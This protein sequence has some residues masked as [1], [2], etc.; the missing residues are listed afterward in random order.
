MGG[1]WQQDKRHAY[2][3]WIRAAQLNPYVPGVFGGLGEWYQQHGNDP[4]RAKRCLAKAVDLDCTGAE[5]GQLLADLYLADGSDDLCEAHLL[6]VTEA[7]YAQPW[8]WK[9]LGFLFL[10]QGHCEKA[11][12]ALQN[13]LSADRTD[14]ACWEGLC[15]AY[16]GIGRTHTAVKVA[17][18]VVELDPGRVSGHWQSAQACMRAN[19]AVA[20]LQHFE[21]AA[22][23]LAA[24]EDRVAQRAL[25]AQP[26]AI[27]K[28]ECLVA[29]AER[30]HAEGLLGR[31]ADASNA[32]LEAVLAL[33][34]GPSAAHEEEPPAFLLW[35]IVYA[36][37][38]WLSR[39]G[40]LFGQDPSLARS[41]TVR[42][43]V[44]HAEARAEPPKFLAETAG[45][46]ATEHRTCGLHGGYIQ[47]LFELAAR[48]ACLR[49]PAAS[50]AE[51]ASAAWADLGSVYFEHSTRF[52]T[53][54]LRTV[55]DD[56][57]AAES[58]PLLAAAAN[59]ALAAVQ[60]D[61]ASA[62]AHNLQGL[63]AM[64]QQQQAALAQHAF[65]M[66]SRRAPLSAMPWANLGFLYF[67]HGDVELAN[68]AF[69]RAQMLDPAAIL[70]WLGQAL[71]AESIGSDECVDLFEACMLL[72]GAS[73]DVADFGYASQVWRLAVGAG[74]AGSAGVGEGRE[75]LSHSSHSRLALAIY[76]ARRYVARAEDGQGAGHHLLGLLLEQNGEYECA[77]EA[78]QVAHE[79][80]ASSAEAG[81]LREWGALTC[82][83]R[84]QC[85]AA[86]Y[87]AA[88]ESYGRG[89]ALLQSGDVEGQLVAEQGGAAQLFYYVLGYGL[90]LFFDGQLEESLARF[91]QV[92][93][94]ADGA[95]EQRPHVAVMLAQVLWALGSEEHRALARQHLVEA[96]GEHAGFLPGLATLFAIGLLQDDGELV[97]AVRSELMQVHG[98][99][100]H[101]VPRLES[102][103][104]VLRDDPAGGRR[105]VAR[106]LHRE[107][108]DASLWLLLAD[109]DA[110]CQRHSSAAG[111]AAA[112]LQLFQQAMRGRQ[113]W[114][115]IPPRALLNSASLHVATSAL[116]VESRALA[117]STAG[118][119]AA[120]TAARRA[121]MYGPWVDGAWACLDAARGAAV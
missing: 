30:W 85:S 36:A 19:D 47:Q 24:A 64:Q 49:I 74:S 90:A 2:A 109:F 76:A 119:R 107:P 34:A 105:A 117:A 37:C 20:A 8:A 106:A 112:A 46:A 28:A 11:S 58:Q 118:Q 35:G 91:E 72:E 95:P 111:A 102:Y 108:A 62:R 13:A 68:K 77:A 48:A 101:S 121:V 10:R 83:A 25:W 69:S 94:L 12:V 14:R 65:I 61:S 32:A 53:V 104:A 17:Q 63:V 66:A 45:L 31:V 39:V 84:A 115:A 21:R 99:P 57:A 78:Y 120:Q 43:L 54:P 18:K 50:S 7:K 5:A 16:M 22:E 56:D 23:C 41:E 51:L 89:A 42:S 6:R 110:L 59:C 98:D 67:Q 52:F 44:G 103:L 70:V 93:A 92:L 29:C 116:A 9:R 113:A 87:G 96:M 4:E 26:L 27:G 38:V 97:G 1:E 80:A 81:G 114:G 40:A 82:L 86:Q 88:V 75:A 3:S 55:G 71:I 73:N 60:L 33:L 100:D 79:R 15:D